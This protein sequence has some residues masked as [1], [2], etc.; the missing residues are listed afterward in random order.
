MVSV[1][2]LLIQPDF[3]ML[4]LIAVENGLYRQ[5]SDINV[6]SFSKATLCTSTAIR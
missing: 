1:G 5:I 2:E 3:Q 4:K 6:I